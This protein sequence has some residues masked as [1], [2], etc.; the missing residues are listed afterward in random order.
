[1]VA[2]NCFILFHPQGG[3][4]V[5]LWAI[6]QRFGRLILPEV[7]KT[8]RELGSDYTLVA[9]PMEK[10]VT[11]PDLWSILPQTGSEEYA[12]FVH[13][14]TGEL[15]ADFFQSVGISAADN[16]ARLSQTGILMVRPETPTARLGRSQ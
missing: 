8:L 12:Y 10:V 6:S 1:M 5:S 7:E 9:I 13:I 4:R 3:Y 2:W 11:N 16:F 15:A 14:V